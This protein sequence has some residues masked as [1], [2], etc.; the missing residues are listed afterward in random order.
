[1]LQKRNFFLLSFL[2]I[3]F[4]QSIFAQK[5]SAYNVHYFKTIPNISIRALEV[6]SDS[7]AWFAANRGVWGYTEDAGKTWHIDSIKVDSVYLHFRSMAVLNDST[8][9]LLSIASPAYMFKT[10]NK[11]KTWMLV[12]KDT[13]KNIFFDC[14]KFADSNNGVAIADPIDG[15]FQIIFTEDGG[16]TWEKSLNKD[17]V[18]ALPGEACFASSNSNIAINGHN[19]WFVTGGMRSRIYHYGD[20]SEHFEVFDTPLP[21]GG[22]LTGIFSVDFTDELTGVIAGGNYEKADSSFVSLAITYDGG[23]TWTPIKGNKPFFGSCVKFGNEDDVY[24]T[25][26]AGTFRYN[27]KAVKIYEVK[28]KSGA[29]LKFNTLRFSPSKKNL[30]L[31]GDKG[32]IALIS[33]SH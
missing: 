15:F 26:G 12:Y 28:D 27:S 10:T 20:K 6:L 31:A 5:D 24:V 33:L 14:M 4:T 30:W 9:L 17:I 18:H 2:L 8:V 7:K 32:S 19:L 25:G 1:M 11:G 29:S 3:A 23:K 16:A 21:E 22:Q 13:N